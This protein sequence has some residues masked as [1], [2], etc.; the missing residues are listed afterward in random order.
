MMLVFEWLQKPIPSISMY[1]TRALSG[2]RL[3]HAR[4][5]RCL[6]LVFARAVRFY[7]K[8]M[9]EFLLI[10]EREMYTE[11]FSE[12]HSRAAKK[13]FIL[14]PPGRGYLGHHLSFFSVSI[15]TR[16]AKRAHDAHDAHTHTHVTHTHTNTWHTY[17]IYE[18]MKKTIVVYAYIYI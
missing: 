16:G 8:L 10:L 15:T 2:R 11:K 1:T 6:L 4:S 13:Y 17:T 14:N 9:C 3:F 12:S 7:W 5:R 18:E